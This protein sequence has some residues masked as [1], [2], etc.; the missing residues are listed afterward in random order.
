MNEVKPEKSTV[1]SSFFGDPMELNLVASF[2]QLRE[3]AAVPTFR[4]Q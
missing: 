2:I 3:R 4:E 1:I